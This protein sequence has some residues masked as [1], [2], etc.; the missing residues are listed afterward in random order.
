L[1]RWE[2]PVALEASGEFVLCEEGG[3]I[4]DRGDALTSFDF[5]G[6]V[7]WRAGVGRVFGVPA[8]GE[9]MM[10]VATED[11]A[12]LAVLDRATGRILW[13]IP[14]ERA[15]TTGPVL[16]KAVV[17]V[18]SKSGLA[19]F[20]LVD[21]GLLWKTGG[22]AAVGP[23]TL[24]KGR[25]AYI[26]VREEKS[27]EEKSGAGTLPAPQTVASRLWLLLEFFEFL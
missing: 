19:A 23:L 13:Q 24:H 14:L 26:R 9:T 27:G 12:G 22:G 15:P 16:R 10:V 5:T 18:G 2:L 11:P 6:S 17:Y 8:V 1:T 7:V 21:G 4:A 20:R 3:L 25:L